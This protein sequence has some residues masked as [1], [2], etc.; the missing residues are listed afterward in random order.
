MAN[1]KK[2]SK[3]HTVEEQLL[4]RVRAM[5]GICEKTRVIGRRGFFDRVVVLPNGMG[6][7]RVIFVECKRPVGGRL[8]V[9]QIQRHAAYRALGA[10][11]ALVLSTADIDR[12]LS[13]SRQT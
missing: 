4:R 7:G 11:V 2:S 9:H 8:S 10:E 12:L 13:D 3:E 5:G 1:V 6:S